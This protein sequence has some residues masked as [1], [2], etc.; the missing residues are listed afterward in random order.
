MERKD[1]GKKSRQG[2]LSRK[3]GRL[4]P[5]KVI[6][7]GFFLQILIGSLLL[8]LPFATRS[9]RS[10]SYADALFTATSATCVTG[11]VVQDTY[12]YWSGFGQAVILML[13]Q[14]GGMGVVTMAVAVFALAGKRIGF[15][16]RYAMQESIA[17]P[18]V[19]G[20]VRLTYFI[21]KT[22]LLLEGIGAFLLALR[23]CPRYGLAKG[24]WTSVFHAV[25]AFCNAGFDLMGREKAFASLTLSCGDPLVNLV[26]MCLIVTGGLGFFLWE[27]LCTNHLRI[28]RCR[29]QTKV[30]LTTTAF[31]ILLPALFFFFWEFRQP[32]WAGLSGGQRFWASLFQ[33]VTPRT[34]GFNTV[35]LTRLQ[36]PSVLII[37]F[38]MLVGGSPGSTAGGMKT[39]TLAVLLLCI[40]SLFRN[41]QSLHCFKRRV[42][43]EVLKSAVTISLLYSI[44]TLSCGMLI[45]CL[46]GVSLTASLFEAA[47]AIG[48]VGLSL[49]ITGELSLLSRLLL[50]GLMYFGR[51]G[52]LTMIYA[53]AEHQTGAAAQLPLEKIT[54]G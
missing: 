33:S 2:T 6:I 26:I 25:S 52:C 37:L 1:K 34:A 3:L 36:S 46:E 31:L 22:T 13:I 53:F 7:G 42:G 35:D 8:S 10:A 17:A 43:A 4:T 50:I 19:G 21:V 41:E 40:P 11:L 12:S 23:Y 45:C 20:I 51:V 18:Q 38:L 14:I 27:D 47:S 29:L 15:R 28:R 49:G 32:A 30:V 9:G 39:T 44:L 48:T 54:V 16:Q 24:L 5:A